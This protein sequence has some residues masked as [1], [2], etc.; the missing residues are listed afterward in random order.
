MLFATKNLLVRY[1]LVCAVETLMLHNSNLVFATNVILPKKIYIEHVATR[2]LFK[3]FC[4]KCS[5]NTNFC[6]CTKMFKPGDKIKFYST[7]KVFTVEKFD[8]VLKLVFLVE[9]TDCF[10]HYCYNFDKV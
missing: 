4:K 10:G 9:H 5:G 8:D 7:S 6:N 1:I 3:M 2:C